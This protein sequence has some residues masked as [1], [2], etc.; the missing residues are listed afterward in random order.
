MI[1]KS[2]NRFKEKLLFLSMTKELSVFL[3]CSTWVFDFQSEEIVLV[4]SAT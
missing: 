2:N 4:F 3:K 1:N